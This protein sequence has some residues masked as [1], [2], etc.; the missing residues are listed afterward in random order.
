MNSSVVTFKE[1][2][3]C[4]VQVKMQ[5]RVYKNTFSE[6]LVHGLIEAFQ[7]IKA[8]PTY[9]VVILTGYDNYFCSGG[10]QE[11][12][13]A[14][15]EGR[16]KFTDVNVYALALECEIPVIAAMQGHGIG[17]GF[18][19][20]LF[21]DFVILSRESVYTTNFMQYG[22]T[23]GMGATYIVPKK[24]GFSLGE[25]MLL[26]AGNYRGAEL[27]KRGISFKV[28]SRKDVLSSALQLA[29][30]VAEKPR[31]S[32]IT[33]KNHM[34]KS[35]REQLPN[36]VNQE[37]AMHDKTFHEPEVKERIIKLFGG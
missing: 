16:G 23:P 9:K 26:N 30:Q 13:L 29:R 18:V 25:E 27:E 35:I 24:M 21:A 37:I 2:E 34:V 32:L 7:K 20:G 28:V 14:I 10:T 1:V 6:E 33:L 5:D 4:I 31:I 36:V 3:P 8:N 22:F 19:M 17:G 11:G 15:H 12:L